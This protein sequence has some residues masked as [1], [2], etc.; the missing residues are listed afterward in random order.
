MSAKILQINYRLNGPRAE[1]E[2]ENLPYAQPIADIA[3]LRWKVWIINEGQSEA[4]GIYLFGR[5]APPVGAAVQVE[6]AIGKDHRFTA[7]GV[8]IRDETTGEVKGFA[9]E[10]RNLPGEARQLLARLI[11]DAAREAPPGR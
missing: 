8:V 10:F 6:I 7:W 9:V 5:Q 4:G 11:E 2:R 3:G 1:Y